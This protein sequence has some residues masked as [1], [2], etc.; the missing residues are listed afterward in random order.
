LFT[1]TRTALSQPQQFLRTVKHSPAHRVSS[2]QDDPGII[3]P[4]TASEGTNERIKREIYGIVAL[5]A[6]RGSQRHRDA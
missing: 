1:G 6:C 5:A 4:Q 2:D 3:V